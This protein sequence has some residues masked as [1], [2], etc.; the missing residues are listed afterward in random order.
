[1]SSPNVQSSNYSSA[2]I[3]TAADYFD[4]LAE[5]MR[6]PAARE[7]YHEMY[8][9]MRQ[10][11]D[12][13]TDGQVFSN[14]FSQLGWVCESCSIPNDM[15]MALQDLR[16]RVSLHD[17]VDAWQLMHD[18][19]LVAEF[20]GRLYGVVLPVE[21]MSKIPSLQALSAPIRAGRAE[22]A[23]LRA[24][25]KE[26]GDNYMTVVADSEET[27]GD[28][29]RVAYSDEE[30]AADWTYLKD[31]VH[32]GSTLSLLNLRLIANGQSPIVNGQSYVAR[33]IVYEPDFLM[34][35]SELAAVFEPNAVM[36]ENY[37]LKGLM[38][39]E[40]TY[41]TLLGNISGQILDDIVFQT[42][43]HPATYADSVRKTFARYSLDFWL[44]MRDKDVS[45][46]FHREA[47]AQFANIKQIVETQMEMVYGFDLS[48]AMLEPS[49]VRPAVGLAGRMDYLQMDGSRLI[50]QK[51]GKYDEYRHTHKE[52]HFVQMML[53]NL[54]L[55][56]RCQPYLL[57]SRYA[58]GLMLERPYIT[59]LRQ[60]V[61]MRNRIVAQCERL[62]N[63]NVRQ[64]FES[65][66]V[67]AFRQR[68]ISDKLWFD[69]VRPRIEAMLMPFAK[70]TSAS[71]PTQDFFYRF[72][73]FLAKEQW[74]A[75]MGNG[76]GGHGYSDLWNNP[77]LVRI[78]NGDMYAGLRIKRLESSAA[79]G[80]GIDLITFSIPEEQRQRAIITN[81]RLG[82][83]VQVY[84]YKGEEPSV[85]Q[86]FTLRARITRLAP[87]EVHVVLNNAQRNMDV[88]GGEDTLFALEH[89]RVEAGNSLL[90]SGLYSLLTS[91]LEVQDR[92]FLRYLAEPA[93]EKAL[94][95]EYG[96]FRDL[97]A[98]ATAAKDLFLVIG[99]PGSGKTSCALRF[100]VE[101]ALRRKPD[102]RLLLMA[103]TNRAVDEL[104][105][106][107][108]SIIKEHPD[109]LYDYL[110]IG[111][112][113][114]NGQWSMVNEKTLANRML[115]NRV[116]Q[117]VCRIDEL[118]TLL[119]TTRVMVGTTTTMMQRQQVLR[120]LHFDV[121]FVDEASQIL[122]PYLLPFF[123]LG[124][125]DKFVL[126]GDQKQLS[127]VVMQNHD[128]AAITDPSLNHLG[129]TNCTC[130]VF[131]RMLHRLMT[132]G[133]TD[134]YMQIE[135]QGR[136]HP[137]LYRFVN[138]SFYLGVLRSVPLSHQQRSLSDFYKHT[139]MA[140]TSL[141]P[142]LAA[143][144]VLFVD[145][146]PV[147][148]GDCNDKINPVEATIVA[149]CLT[150]IAA[151]YQANHRQLTADHVGIIVPYRNQIAMVRAKLYECGLQRLADATID[152][153]ERFQGSQRDII[154]YSFTVRHVGQLRF[155]TSSTY[156]E[157]DDRST[158]PYPVDRKLNVALTRA[159]EQMVLV[160]NAALLRRNA[161][162]AR[163]IDH[164]TV[165]TWGDK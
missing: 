98:R 61:E 106:M 51:S 85:T 123:T 74:L 127:A 135:S 120:K 142:W 14:F 36:P 25:V 44:F 11:C 19:R 13:H 63:G 150:D 125:I 115:A 114:V 137:D 130:S 164:M 40:S 41:Y 155:L 121:A 12:A 43:D 159:R 143:E 161:L 69:Y 53:Y 9:M 7:L 100:M 20:V 70:H 140:G 4:Q 23:L 95:G 46:R 3:P 144:R 80:A 162:F 89:D 88:F 91:P 87:D 60:A 163:M 21:L 45:E 101:E 29:L 158:E 65:M 56:R 97:V 83:T 84:A 50:E 157:S 55:G 96:A 99:P 109:L 17:D 81:F 49:F 34:S 154:I 5:M 66:Q 129:L 22:Y 27:N 79:D 15:T 145:C 6:K 31:F 90:V 110:R 108:E 8:S 26:V 93:A 72:Y 153:V 75:R 67:D 78:E 35:P 52:P 10:L 73:E 77:A 104:C 71:K 113:I 94:C 48:Q 37:F 165:V 124:T 59:L 86:Q 128:E 138:A 146:I 107:L 156:L 58:E 32:E 39:R 119:V 68:D 102:S 105:V 131:D 28:V 118:D 136:M 1:M 160:G 42:P 30:H 82:D 16:R 139:P 134:L 141:M 111:S 148:D 132:M 54:M 103:Y 122:E 133:R 62:A 112:S 47:R 92:F 151:L 117:T 116:G 38:P 64:F 33:W 149:K 147:G 18:I 2:D 57:Y 152:T 126:V 24:R 76:A